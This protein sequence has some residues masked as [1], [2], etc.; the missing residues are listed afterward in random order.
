[1][2]FKNLGFVIID[3]QHKFGVETRNT[4]KD[5]GNAD[6]VYLTATPIPRTLALVLFGDMEVSSIIEK[7]VGRK[8]IITR[9]F[10]EDQL[11][12]VFQHVKKRTR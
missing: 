7:P 5:K 2:I 8:D 1:M 10:S 6:V 3:E 11:G 4:L 12:A 9:Y